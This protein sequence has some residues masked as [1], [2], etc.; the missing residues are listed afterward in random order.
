MKSSHPGLLFAGSFKIRSATSGLVVGLFIL[1]LSSWLI[2]GRLEI[3]GPEPLLSVRRGSL[4]LS[5]RHCPPG[6]RGSGPR[7]QLPGVEAL[8]PRS[9]LLPLSAHVLSLSAGVLAS[10]PGSA[11]WQGG[12]GSCVQQLLPVPCSDAMQPLSP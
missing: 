9:A 6:A 12:A 2:L 1:S 4:L 5:G 3:E 8:S 11:E 7:S 10:Q